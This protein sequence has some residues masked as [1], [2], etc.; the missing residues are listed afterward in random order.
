MRYGDSTSHSSAMTPAGRPIVVLA[1]SSGRPLAGGIARRLGIEPLPTRT[2]RFP[3]GEYDV[4]VDPG[5]RNADAYLVQSLGPPVNDHLVELL[6]LLDAVRRAGAARLTAV[7]PYLGYARKDRRSTPGE[8]VG[9]RVAA[10]LIVGAGAEGA[11]LVD[12]HVPQVDSIFSVPLDVLSAVPLLAGA[13]ASHVPSDAVVVAPDLGAVH[14]AEDYA[15]ELGLARVAV[16]RKARVSGSDVEALDVVGDGEGRTALVV[17][18]MISTGSTLE[19]AVSHMRE[20][21]SIP[22]LAIAATH[23]LFVAD[24]VSRLERLGASTMVVTDS[25]TPAGL[26][27]GCRTVSLEGLLADA[28]EHRS[29]RSSG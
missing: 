29:S 4:A 13:V 5:V 21:W 20:Q 24:A 15:D 17:D 10:D 19:A 12:P 11:I 23:G 8:A 26:P 9:L 22:S 14:L 25:V 3:D 2:E 1:G 6:L 16:V 18:D 27:T 7:I 28:V